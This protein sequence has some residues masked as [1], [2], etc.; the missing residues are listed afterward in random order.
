MADKHIKIFVYSIISILI[1]LFF[2]APQESKIDV[3][4]VRFEGTSS[5][6]LRFKNIRMYFYDV[7]E[8]QK[9]KQTIY[10]FRNQVALKKEK[11]GI[12]FSILRHLHNDHFY[13]MPKFSDAFVNEEIIKIKTVS[14]TASDTLFFKHG[15]IENTW[16][17][18]AKFYNCIKEDEN[19]FFAI[20]DNKEIK[21]LESK[22]EKSQIKIALKDYFDLTKKY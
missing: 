17:F 5:A 20:I 4:K 16:K 15:D 18:A 2:V 22:R 14:K 6:I 7:Q 10:S 11:A 1:I 3:Q 12:Q 8:F 19:E 21:M 9:E 13:I